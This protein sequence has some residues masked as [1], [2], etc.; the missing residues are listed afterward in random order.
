LKK[1]AASFFDY[2]V[3]PRIKSTRFKSFRTYIVCPR[4]S[5]SK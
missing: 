2:S 1:S 4:H 5:I 3:V